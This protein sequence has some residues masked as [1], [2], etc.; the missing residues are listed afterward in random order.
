MAIATA[1]VSL[2]SR[3]RDLV[4][5]AFFAIHVPIIFLVDAAPILPAFL[6]SDLS[7]TLREF[8]IDTYHDKFFE[9]T[10][11]AW[12]TFFLLMELFYHVP[13][14]IWALR[15]LK[16]DNPLVPVNLL[17]FGVQSFLTSAICLVEVWSWTDRSVVQ[18]QNITMLYGPYVALGAFMAVDMFCRLRE[19][20]GLKSKLE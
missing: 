13:L 4:Y 14:S 18:K 2:W 19:R 3:K 6:Q 12:F 17:V 11:T 8:Y 10:P 15:G 7:V 16:K 9:E 20:L 1:P 5:F